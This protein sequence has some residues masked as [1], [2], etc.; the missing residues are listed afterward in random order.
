MNKI[1]LDK[2]FALFG[3]HWRPKIIAAVNG[4]EVKI[5]KVKVNSSGTITPMETSSSWCGKAD[6]ALSSAIASSNW[7]QENA[8]SCRGGASSTAL[9]QTR[10]LRSYVLNRL[11]FETPATSGANRLLQ[12]YRGSNG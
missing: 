10:R 1:N 3:E 7:H 12:S 11:A 9:V 5:I 2:K 6:S 4:Q 8:S